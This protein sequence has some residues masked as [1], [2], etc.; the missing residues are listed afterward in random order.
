M[1]SVL[2]LITASGTMNND[3]GIEEFYSPHQ[4][5]LEDSALTGNV[6]EAQEF[7]T[8]RFLEYCEEECL[9]AKNSS[10]ECRKNKTKM[11]V[12]DEFVERVIDNGATVTLIPELTMLSGK[13]EQVNVPIGGL[14]P[15]KDV[16]RQLKATVRGDYEFVVRHENTTTKVIIKGALYVPGCPR[17]LISMR[18]L[19][20]AG[21]DLYQT[22]GGK[23]LFLLQKSSKGNN[24]VLTRSDSD[25][26]LYTIRDYLQENDRSEIFPGEEVL[27]AMTGEWVEINDESPFLYEANAYLAKTFTG[28]SNLADFVH[29]RFGHISHSNKNLKKYFLEI[30]GQDYSAALKKAKHCDSCVY[31]KA[32][33]MPFPKAKRS[34]VTRPLERVHWDLIGKIPVTGQGGFEYV[35]TWVDEFTGMYFAIPIKKKS[36]V[37]EE[38]VKFELLAEKHWRGQYRFGH[39]EVSPEIIAFM[40]DGAGENTS[41]EL[42]KFLESENIKH[43]LMVPYEHEQMGKVE[44]ANRTIWEGAEAIRYE[45]GFPPSFWPFAVSTFVAI[46]NMVPT[47]SVKGEFEGKT[48]YEIWHNHSVADFKNLTKHFRV[49][50]CSAYAVI[51]KELR[52][53]NQKRAMKCTFLGY[54]ENMKGYKMMAPNGVVFTARNVYFDE[55]EYI[56]RDKTMSVGEAIDNAALTDWMRKREIADQVLDEAVEDSTLFNALNSKVLE[57]TAREKIAARGTSGMPSY[58][59]DDDKNDHSN[60]E[61]ANEDMYDESLY[62]DEMLEAK[63]SESGDE[64][65]RPPERV[66]RSRRSYNPTSKSLQNIVNTQEYGERVQLAYE[67]PEVIARLS[68]EDAM[69]DQWNTT[70]LT[71]GMVEMREKLGKRV[72]LLEMCLVTR[73]HN[74]ELPASR[75]AMLKCD[76]AADWCLGETV[77]LDAF[78]RLEVLALVDRPSSKNVMKSGWVYDKKIGL[79]G[80]VIYKSRLVAKGYSQSYDSDYFDVFTPTMQLKT[81]RTLLSVA[82]AD[83]NIKTQS[84]DVSTAFL[85]ADME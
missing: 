79:N 41:N 74:T 5:L 57:R 30:F 2:L 68:I 82:A 62:D 35:M 59:I 16:V 42:G 1:V 69:I 78:M 45:A 85:Y 46:R 52:K 73:E 29:A 43:E 58:M 31:A 80:E 26:G 3:I 47:T 77:E 39:L 18:S 60:D 15:Q 7:Y 32:T 25:Y 27:M 19:G 67:L 81:L 21:I 55:T 64:E 9:M 83:K 40:S 53:R 6:S 22:N 17:V 54:A 63:H 23:T 76:N 20:Q 12:S 14:N 49:P 56:W 71:W 8:A 33:R 84:W 11:F 34:V 50:G 61:N 24:T 10:D 37:F 28:S 70:E 72:E 13:L 48:P 51:P 65:A 36:E 4:I 38:V 44:R 75:A 66:Q